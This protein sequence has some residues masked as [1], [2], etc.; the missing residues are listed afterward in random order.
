[1]RSATKNRIGKDPA[2]IAWI[3]TQPCAVA[4][5][6]YE[7]FCSGHITAHH[8]GDHGSSQTA[9][10]LT[11]IPLCVAHHLNGAGPYAIHG[12]LGKNWWTFHGINRDELISDFNVL[13][14]A[15]T[16]RGESVMEAREVIA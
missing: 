9:P 11:A 13:F 7:E 5:T 8:A 2:Y 12:P 1:M 15:E 6:Q 3:H 16:G 14:E 10:D 4:G